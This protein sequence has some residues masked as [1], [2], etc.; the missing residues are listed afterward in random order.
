MYLAITT[1]PDIT[2]AVSILA[3]FNS[4]PGPTH[5]KAVKHLFRYLKGTIDLKLSL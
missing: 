1:H 5:W 3:R 4:N 2:N